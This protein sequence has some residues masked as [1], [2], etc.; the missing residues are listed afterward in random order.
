[1]VTK[2]KKPIVN[3]AENFPNPEFHS[4][5]LQESQVSYTK[6]SEKAEIE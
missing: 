5:I 2:N 4:K 6:V 1:M 3:I